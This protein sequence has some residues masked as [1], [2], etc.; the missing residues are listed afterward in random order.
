MW[1]M[2]ALFSLLTTNLIFTRALG[3]S[4]MLAAAKNRSNLIVLSLLMTLFSGAACFG[5][6]LIC[7]PLGL[8]AF[9]TYPY[10][11]GLPLVFTLV[12]GVIYLAALFLC[13]ILFRRQYAGYKKYIHLSAFNCAVMG[14]LYLAFA[15]GGLNQTLADAGSLRLFGLAEASMQIPWTAV[16]FGIQ[17]GL[18]FLLAALMLSAVR[19]RLY[20]NDVPAAFRGFPAVIVFI[21]ILS[22]ALYAIGI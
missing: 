16:L 4:T 11:L 8:A 19:E 5:M 6:Q 13:G 17:E 15:P 10:S 22:M 1:L 3:T 18:G 20:C 2:T 9:L 7:Y 12:I 21:G 14:T